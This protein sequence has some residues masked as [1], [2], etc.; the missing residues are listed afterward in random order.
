MHGVIEKKAEVA[1][2]AC[3][4]MRRRQVQSRGGGVHAVR[5]RAL[6]RIAPERTGLPS[7]GTSGAIVGDV[8][9]DG[10]GNVTTTLVC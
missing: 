8:V 9:G 7:A 6:I 5:L 1:A 3:A 10:V 4:R 2:C